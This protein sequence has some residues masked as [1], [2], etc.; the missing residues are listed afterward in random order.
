M[1]RC[2]KRNL[3]F[4]SC[5][6]AALASAL[7][8]R[9][10][11]SFS[12]AIDRALQ[13]SPRVKSAEDDLKKAQA[14]VGVMK[15]IYVPSVV[16]GAGLGTAYG[17]MLTV[18]TIFTVTAQS[19]VYSPQQ[20]SYIHSAKYDLQAAKFALADAREQVAED[21]AVSYLTLNHDQE[22]MAALSQESDDALKLVSI[23]EDRVAAHLDAPM[24]LK[25]AR[26]DAL[27]MR[28]QLLQMQDDMDAQSTHLAELTALARSQMVAQADSIPDLP[29]ITALDSNHLPETPG[30]RAAEAGQKARELRARADAEYTWRPN[31]GF[32]AQYGRISPIE[33]VGEFYN[34]HGE[35]NTVSVGV[36]FTFPLL[37]KVRMATA[38]Q[39]AADAAHGATD[40]EA[41]QQ[42]LAEGVRKLG[43]AT[44]ELSVKAQLADLDY[45]LAQDQLQSVLIAEHASSGG[46]VLTPKDE[47]GARI[48]E[49]QK[50]LE[51]LNTRL[52]AA[53]A[54]IDY[55]RQTGQLEQWLQSL[56]ISATLPH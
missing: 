11:V 22:A 35:Y 49:R 42:A 52:D 14:E 43:R 44:T 30:M 23:V 50:Y 39:S 28:L 3:I 53:R 41:Q 4:V 36:Q 13:H 8:A 21:A 16:V 31:I 7:P 1:D 10:Q 56:H 34:L 26:R 25:K 32:G 29:D 5:M 19:L 46:P 40:I 33:N 47:E 45:G 15:D 6:M 9:A 51:M 55:L 27:E 2:M 17:I 37:D 38:K 48:Q 12:Q 54:K 24:D 18:P 20:A